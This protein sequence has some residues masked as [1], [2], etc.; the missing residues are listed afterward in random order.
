MHTGKAYGPISTDRTWEV[1]TRFIKPLA[2]NGE[3]QWVHFT[4]A[5]YNRMSLTAKSFVDQCIELDYTHH[6]KYERAR[7]RDVRITPR[8]RRRQIA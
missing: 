4:S 6:G 3:R 1:F 8:T 5:D 2:E 7:L